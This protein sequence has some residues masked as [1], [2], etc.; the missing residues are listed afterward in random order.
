M[1][2]VPTEFEL[3]PVVSAVETHRHTVE[4]LRSRYST[5]QNCGRSDDR[6]EL[7]RK[8]VAANEVLRQSL[9]GLR[10]QLQYRRV[11]A[12]HDAPMRERRE[13]AENMTAWLDARRA[14]LEATMRQG[15]SR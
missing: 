15:L 7:Q 5:C 12:V 13:S 10:S 14:E 6:A 1:S 11:A 9:D 2:T 8:F 4:Q 3:H